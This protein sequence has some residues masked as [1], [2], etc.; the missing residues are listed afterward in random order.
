M[1]YF[2]SKEKPVLNYME[3]QVVDSCNLKCNY[4][5][6]FCYLIDKT[7]LINVEDIK[8]DFEVLSKKVNIKTIRL[9]GGEPLLHPHI[10]EF[11]EVTR[12]YF[13][14]ST[15]KLVTNGL[16]LKYK[17]KAFWN[18]YKENKIKIDISYYYKFKNYLNEIKDILKANGVEDTSKIEKIGIFY[19]LFN[20]EGNSNVEKAFKTCTRKRCPC[21]WNHKLYIC[22]DCFR[23]YYNK[24]NNTN[25]ELPPYIDIYKY[26]GE[27]I[28]KILSSKKPPEACKYCKE[29]FV[30]KIWEQY[31]KE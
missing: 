21:L 27:K 8:K 26:S 7:I 18:V 15:I 31:K 14:T 5:S 30:P 20:E 1:F 6:H 25:I 24:K 4:C 19:D 17:D 29:I 3:V 16:L 2:L 28:Y 23:Y 9:L 10:N 13:P 12:Y 22:P 11:M